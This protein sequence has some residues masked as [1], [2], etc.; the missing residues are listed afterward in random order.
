MEEEKMVLTNLQT[1][2]EKSQSGGQ[3][4]AEYFQLSGKIHSDFI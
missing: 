1:L 3:V 4:S 2:G